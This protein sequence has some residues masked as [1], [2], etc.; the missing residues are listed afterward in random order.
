[1]VGVV[2]SMVFD[3]VWDNKEEIGEEIGNLVETTV[4]TVKEK[5]GG[6]IDSVKGFV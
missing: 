6:I 1:M 4:D 2:G 5:G 3:Y